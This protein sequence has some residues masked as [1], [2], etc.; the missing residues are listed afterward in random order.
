M[1]QTLETQ[2]TRSKGRVGEDG[3]GVQVD[4]LA[5]RPDRVAIERR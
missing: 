2:T 1:L 5:A 4:D 3:V